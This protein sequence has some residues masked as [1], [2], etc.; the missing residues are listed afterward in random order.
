MPCAEPGCPNSGM[1]RGWRSLVR[2]DTDPLR[3]ELDHLSPHRT[4]DV[5]RQ[6]LRAGSHSGG[7]PCQADSDRSAGV[8]PRAAR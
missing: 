6:R 8:E 3:Q 5:L 1:L 7:R 2:T 4:R